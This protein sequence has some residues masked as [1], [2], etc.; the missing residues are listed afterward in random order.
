MS[1]PNSDD[2]DTQ[3][4]IV[5]DVY[6]VNNDDDHDDGGGNIDFNGESTDTGEESSR[7]V[8]NNSGRD[9]GGSTSHSQHQ[10]VFQGES[11]RSVPPIRSVWSRYHPFE[12][13]IGDPC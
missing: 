7:N 6:N 9:N 3:L 5:V 11:S 12:L 4:E 10:N 1:D 8:G 13:N 2:D